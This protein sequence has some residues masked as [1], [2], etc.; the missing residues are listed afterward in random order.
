MRVIYF[1]LFITTSS[2]RLPFQ[3]PK[4][5]KVENLIKLTAGTRTGLVK[6]NKPEIVGLIKEFDVNNDIKSSQ[7]D[8]DWKLVWTTEKV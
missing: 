2:L 5:S 6:S 4:S 3:A 7:L 1:C 8:G